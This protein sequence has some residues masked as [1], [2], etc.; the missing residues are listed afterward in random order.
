MHSNRP[1]FMQVKDEAD[2]TFISEVFSGCVHYHGLIK[3][4]HAV[5]LYVVSGWSDS[6]PKVV[7]DRVEV[8]YRPMSLCQLCLCSLSCPAKLKMLELLM[9]GILPC[10]TRFCVDRIPFVKLKCL[11]LENNVNKICTF[12]PELSIVSLGNE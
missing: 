4:L 1:K 9:C 7:S 12:S 2:T 6:S 8:W 5:Q 3:V 11:A 10:L